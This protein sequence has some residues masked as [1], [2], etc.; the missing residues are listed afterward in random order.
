M[1]LGSRARSVRIADNLSVI[2]EPL[3]GEV[4][5]KILRIEGYQL[6]SVTD[7]YGCILEFLDRS[8]YIVFQVPPQLY[9]RG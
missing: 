8:R 1:F 2:S 9:L 6:V 3:V 4:S 7:P 5:A